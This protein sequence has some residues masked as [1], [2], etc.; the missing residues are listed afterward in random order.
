MALNQTIVDTANAARPNT[1]LAETA[2]SVAG[3]TAVNS[4]LQHLLSTDFS[5]L[6]TTG[7]R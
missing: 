2:I 4:D 6:A 1:S 3:F 5:R 7:D